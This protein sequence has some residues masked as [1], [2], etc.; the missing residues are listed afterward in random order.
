L[1]VRQRAV[2]LDTDVTAFASVAM[3]A[4]RLSIGSVRVGARPT[5]VKPVTDLFAPGQFARLSADERLV[6]PSFERFHAGVRISSPPA[7]GEVER[8]IMELDTIVIDPLAPPTPSTVISV[9]SAIAVEQL[10]TSRST[11]PPPSPPPW[12]RVH[13]IE[14]AIVSSESLEITAESATLA[15]GASTYTALRQA[16]SR[17]SRPSRRMIVVPRI[18][19]SN[20]DARV[21]VARPTE[22]LRNVELVDT[23]TG[24][25]MTRAAFAEALAAGDYLAADDPDAPGA[26]DNA[27][28]PIRHGSSS[29][30]RES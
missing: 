16:L 3:P 8:S 15:A 7:F 18:E 4:R 24:R 25:R 13:E 12:I 17:A 14:W 30:R 10:V 5:V 19:A 6:A 21:V 28:A 23:I 22:N 20:K 11:R 29:R 26:R 9:L 2:P 27:E 1:I